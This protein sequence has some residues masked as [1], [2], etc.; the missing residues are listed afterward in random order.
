M[1]FIAPPHARIALSE[2]QTIQYTHG[3]LKRFADK[4]SCRYVCSPFSLQIRTIDHF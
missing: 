2:L 3:Y 4:E 1:E